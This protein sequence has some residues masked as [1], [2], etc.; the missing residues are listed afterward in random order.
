MLGCLQNSSDVQTQRLMD[1]A[2]HVQGE[3]SATWSA[4]LLNNSAGD[5]TQQVSTNSKE[6]YLLSLRGT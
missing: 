1:S 3:A 6:I 2:L 4:Q 5:Y